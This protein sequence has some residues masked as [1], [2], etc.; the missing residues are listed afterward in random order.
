MGYD[1]ARLT[2]LQISPFDVQLVSEIRDNIC[3]PDSLNEGV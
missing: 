3:T 2:A 1:I